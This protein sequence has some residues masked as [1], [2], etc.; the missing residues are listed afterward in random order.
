MEGASQGSVQG[1]AGGLSHPPAPRAGDAR[2]SGSNRRQA[3]SLA[4]QSGAPPHTLW[5][6]SPAPVKFPAVSL[7][8][9]EQRL[10]SAS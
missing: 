3:A 9:V 2:T 10:P 4:G 5:Q 6:V 8:P 1:R 7:C